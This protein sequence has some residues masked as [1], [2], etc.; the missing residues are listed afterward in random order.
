MCNVIKHVLTPPIQP[1]D[2]V[3]LLCNIGNERQIGSRIEKHDAHDLSKGKAHSA[4]ADAC[5]LA[6]V[7]EAAVCFVYIRTD[8][9]L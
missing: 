8:H 2:S 7:S 4:F 1:V 3:C 5:I 6:Q 9:S